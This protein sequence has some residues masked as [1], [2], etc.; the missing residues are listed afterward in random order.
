MC[1][2]SRH[3]S[4]PLSIEHSSTKLHLLQD[5]PQDNSHSYGPKHQ[6]HAWPPAL[7]VPKYSKA[8]PHQPLSDATYPV[9]MQQECMMW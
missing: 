7:Q 5:P 8:C 3:S 6:A 2:A 1:A 4:C 9:H